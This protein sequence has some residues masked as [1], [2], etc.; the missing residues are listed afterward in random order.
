MD[1]NH[2][3]SVVHKGIEVVG[4]GPENSFEV[5]A[6]PWEDYQNEYESTALVSDICHLNYVRPVAA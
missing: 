4:I 6:A 3:E 1:N 5:V 2:Q